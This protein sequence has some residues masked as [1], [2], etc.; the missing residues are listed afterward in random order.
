MRQRH[1]SSSQPP[2][3]S[4]FGIAPRIAVLVAAAGLLLAASTTA[5]ELAARRPLPKTPVKAP[6]LP[7][8]MSTLAVDGS[9][10][11]LIVKF[12]DEVQARTARGSLISLAAADLVDAESVARTFGM[13]FS[14]LIQLSERDLEQLEERAAARSLVA[15]PDLAGILKVELP[16]AGPAELVAAGEALQLLPEVEFAY[17]QTLG[18]PPP[19][20]IP[21]TTPDYVPLQTYRGPDP[22]MDVDYAW[23]QGY[24]G[25]GVRLSDCEY[26]W[27]YCHEDLVDKDLHPEPGQT[28]HPSVFTFGW[29]EHGTA[30]LGETSGVVNG[31]GVSGMVPD[32]EVYTYPEWTVEEGSRRETAI[33]NAIAGSGI[34]DVVLLEMQTT[35]PG[36]DGLGPAE[37][38]PAVWTVVKTGTDAGVIVVGAAGNGNQDLDSKTYEEYM[39]RGDSGAIIVGAGTSDVNHDKLAE[40]TYGSRVDVQGWGENVFTLGYGDHADF[41]ECQRYT[42]TFRGTSSAAPFAAAAA[43]AIQDAADPPLSPQSLRDLLIQTGIEQGSGGH[44]GPFIDLRAAI[45]QLLNNNLP[46]AEDDWLGTLWET[47]VNIPFETLLANDTDPD[48]D[49][50]SFC[51]FENPE[52]GA[53]TGLFLTSLTYTPPAGCL[54]GLDSFE[55]TV[56]DNRGGKDTATAWIQI[57]GIVCPGSATK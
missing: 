52:H 10:Y 54:V 35:L 49:P 27:V 5:Q 23:A 51:D 17:I 38:D 26:G 34:G 7:P 13:I 47:P 30:V 33:A 15:Q 14:P 36:A 2:P 55:Y 57:G 39:A 41:G 45:V 21:P 37:L 1:R 32:A 24:T 31:Y 18:V 48:G 29:D 56:C 42:D 28:I 25:V 50:L 43:V 4:L 22:G 16:G 20:D 3:A 44:I 12:R 11:R 40:S 9:Q 6:A 53:I 19:D 8:G 46:V